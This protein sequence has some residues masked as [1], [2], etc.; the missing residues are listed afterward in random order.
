MMPWWDWVNENVV[1]TPFAD[2]IGN[3][4]ALPQELFHVLT[5]LAT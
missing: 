5:V 1:L 2:A 4:K 3:Q